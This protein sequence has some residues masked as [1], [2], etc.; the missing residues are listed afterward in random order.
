MAFWRFNC[1]LEGHLARLGSHVGVNAAAESQQHPFL[2]LSW[3]CLGPMLRH[4]GA[5]VG[6]RWVS[7]GAS[8]AM[9]RHLGAL[10]EALGRH[11][12]AKVGLGSIDLELTCGEKATCPNLQTT[13]EKHRF[14]NDLWRQEGQAIVPSWVVGGLIVVLKAILQIMGAIL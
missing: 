4:V 10:R 11:L 7:L 2:G 8:W 6:P 1:G 12:E 9:L 3:A 13:K 5:E 14:F